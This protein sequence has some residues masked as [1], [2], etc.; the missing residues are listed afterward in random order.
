MIFVA[1]LFE[2]KTNKLCGDLSLCAFEAVF[3][4][5][6]ATSWL[7][8]SFHCC[9][10]SDIQQFPS[11]SSF[12]CSHLYFEQNSSS[13]LNELSKPFHFIYV[14]TID[15]HFCA[16]LSNMKRT[17]LKKNQLSSATKDERKLFNPFE[18]LSIETNS[19]EKR[20][21]FTNYTNIAQ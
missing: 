7:D 10:Q 15:P 20:P 11:M 21:I 8:K 4:I 2:M 1:V 17:W 5:L 18:Q 14:T 6:F 9:W 12:E 16:V 3:F 13:L 19:M